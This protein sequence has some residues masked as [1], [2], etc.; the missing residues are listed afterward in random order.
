LFII[1]SMYQ[2]LFVLLVVVPVGV[3]G[4]SCVPKTA[5][6]I[7]AGYR[8]E[9]GCPNANPTSCAGCVS[10]NQSRYAC[11]APATTLWASTGKTCL[12]GNPNSNANWD[13]H[14][15][16]VKWDYPADYGEYCP[17]AN[18]SAPG[19]YD[20][21]TYPGWL[22]PGSYACTKVTGV[23]H[24]WTNPSAGYNSNYNSAGWCTKSF[25]WV[26]P[27]N[28]DR[29]DIGVSSWFKRRSDGGNI[30]YSYSQ[31]GAVDSFTLALCTAGTT[32]TLCEA[33]AGCKW[34]TSGT[35]GTTGTTGNLETTDAVSVGLVRSVTVLMFA[36]IFY[37]MG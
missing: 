27:C 15:N 37:T 3:F 17:P 7:L 2:S 18:A 24:Q 35:T 16:N 14:P 4:Q 32:Q 34:G 13:K 10:K 6:D 36:N 28:C 1:G 11:P 9:A 22:E 31:C 26:D 30:Y 21:A 8:T 25:C 23:T 33:E 5:A 19:G 29:A 12:K 20:G